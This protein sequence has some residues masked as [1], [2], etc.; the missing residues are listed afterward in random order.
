[1]YGNR[2]KELRDPPG[3]SITEQDYNFMRS[4][5]LFTKRSLAR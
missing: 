5:K 4:T 2:K 1:M 3:V